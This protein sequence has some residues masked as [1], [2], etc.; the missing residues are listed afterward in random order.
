[1]I[2]FGTGFVV[3]DYG[4][5]TQVTGRHGQDL[6]QQ[7]MKAARTHLGLATHG[8]PNLF[9][10][11]GPGTGLGSNSIVFML[12]AQAGYVV[13]A[14]RHI[15]RDGAVLDLRP[16]VQAASYADLQRRI[17]RTVWASG[18]ASWYQTGS[19]RIDTLWPDFSVNYWRRT[20]RFDPG[21]YDTV[22][23]LQSRL[24]AARASAFPAA[25]P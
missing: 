8:F 24:D 14:V 5:L 25:A 6:A 11:L 22:P 15:A 9:C 19:G 2:V 21:V 20:R 1:M 7:W 3:T 18:C 10:L 12:E 16:E 17:K 23:A 13:Q 4:A